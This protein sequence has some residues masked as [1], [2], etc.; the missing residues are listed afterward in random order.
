MSARWRHVVVANLSPTSYNY[1]SLSNPPYEF[2]T[3]ATAANVQV[4]GYRAEYEL[5]QQES[6]NRCWR[7]ARKD[8]EDA[9]SI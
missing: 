6:K 1:Y 7:S 9:G 5:I 3:K 8:N 4:K 2:C